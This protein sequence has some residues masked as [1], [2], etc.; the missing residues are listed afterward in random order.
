MSRV[1]WSLCVQARHSISLVDE[2]GGQCCVFARK[3]VKLS[4]ITVLSFMLVYLLEVAG[5]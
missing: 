4:S 5:G 1:L 2:E 3:K